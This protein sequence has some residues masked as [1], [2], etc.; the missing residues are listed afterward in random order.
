[1]QGLQQGLCHGT[2]LAKPLHLDEERPLTEPFSQGGVC[3]S[4][5]GGT[6]NEYRGTQSGC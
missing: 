4:L 3:Y 5:T 2:F 1:M 6:V